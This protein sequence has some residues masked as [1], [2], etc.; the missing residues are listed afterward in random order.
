MTVCQHC[1][2]KLI[3]EG[4]DPGQQISCAQCQGLSTH[5]EIQNVATDRLA[6]RSLWLGLSSILLLFITGIPAIYYGIKSLLRMRFVKPK[7]TDKAAAIAGT[8]LGGCFGVAVGAIFIVGMSIWLLNSLLS[9]TII[10]PGLVVE[11]CQKHFVFE[12]PNNFSPV[13]AISSLGNA[14]RILFSNDSDPQRRTACIH[15]TIAIGGIQA[16]RMIVVAE[17]SE[18]RVDENDLRN[19]KSKENLKWSS[20]GSPINVVKRVYS[21]SPESNEEETNHYSGFINKDG[22]F[23]GVSIAY[24]PDNCSLTELQV[25]KIFA[26]IELVEK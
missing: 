9:V 20:N 3:T 19:A 18:L 17:L 6:W 15:F 4:L 25:Q 5:G 8:T 10:E 14:E 13:Y 24:E 21:A 23:Y 1:N 16:N 26:D 2:A 7:P 22:A 11:R 12:A